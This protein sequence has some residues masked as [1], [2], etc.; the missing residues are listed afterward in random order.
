MKWF[1]PVPIHF[2]LCS[3]LLL[4]QWGEAESG[5]CC[6]QFL[7]MLQEFIEDHLLLLQSCG[8]GPRA[9][10]GVWAAVMN[11]PGLMLHRCVSVDPLQSPVVGFLV[12][13]TQCLQTGE[14]CGLLLN[15]LGFLQSLLSLYGL[16][17]LRHFQSTG[18]L[19]GA[20]ES[21]GGCCFQQRRINP[22]AV[23]TWLSHDAP[24]QSVRF[25]LVVE[26]VAAVFLSGSSSSGLRLR[27]HVRG[28]SELPQS[29]QSSM[30]LSSLSVTD[31]HLHQTTCSV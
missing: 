9:N 20:Q 31:G 19:G 2:N 5:T 27:L 15:N 17:A 22:T 3:W 13:V 16:P 29:A 8:W 28:E 1:C 26:V 25:V 6:H 30:S 12:E 23:T 10:Q 21:G 7:E 11:Q 4:L 18:K 24:P 14:D